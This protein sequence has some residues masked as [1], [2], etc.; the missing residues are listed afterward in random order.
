MIGIIIAAGIALLAS[1]IADRKKTFQALKK[2]GKKFTALL[3]FF[4][5]MLAAV[6]IVLTLIPEKTIVRFL[7]EEDL[8]G[9][10]VLAALFG[11]VTFMPGF[12]V[13]PLAGILLSKGV[14]YTVL[15]GFTTTLM[16]VGVLTYPIEKQY[17]GVKVTILR[18]IVSF[19]IAII[20]AVV[21]GISF[22]EIGV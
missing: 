8:L 1:L 20:I 18:N 13:F 16:M 17:F 4:L 11:S 2:A 15:A 19:V 7:G 10:T 3:P 9:G 12:I 5:T 21:I 6:S 22:A 14:A